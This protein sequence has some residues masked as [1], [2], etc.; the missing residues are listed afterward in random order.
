MALAYPYWQGCRERLS[1]PLLPHCPS[2]AVAE[3]REV[4]GARERRRPRSSWSWMSVPWDD[5]SLRRSTSGCS[6][7]TKKALPWLGLPTARKGGRKGEGGGW[8]WGHA[9]AGVGSCSA[10]S[11]DTSSC[12]PAEEIWTLF[13]DPLVSAPAVFVHRGFGKL[14]FFS[15]EVFSVSEEYRYF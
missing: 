2:S 6:R 5:L 13:V 7:S 15:V 8:P 1:T 11:H 10:A 12:L 14:R 4:E 9:C 3:R